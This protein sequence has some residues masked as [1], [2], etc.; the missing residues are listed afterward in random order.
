MI[1]EVTNRVITVKSNIQTR[2]AMKKILRAYKEMTAASINEK[3]LKDEASEAQKQ[4]YKDFCEVVNA[5]IKMQDKIINKELT[6][7]AFVTGDL[8]ES[9][10]Y[11]SQARELQDK[12]NRM[13]PQIL[14]MMPKIL[15]GE[16]VPKE[17]LEDIL[18]DMLNDSEG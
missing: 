13:Y 6:S 12:F 9:D 1:N 7:L 3:V 8:E 2:E 10:K 11:A 5:C 16:D 15:I 18:R 17:E 14:I 4:A